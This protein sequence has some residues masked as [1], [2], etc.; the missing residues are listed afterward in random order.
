MGNAQITTQTLLYD[1]THKIILQL[2]MQ[3]QI[4]KQ[5]TR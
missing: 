3:K 5:S 2:D 4:S 1:D